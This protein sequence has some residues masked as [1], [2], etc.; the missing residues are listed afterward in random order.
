MLTDWMP[1]TE[2]GSA[3]GFIWMSS[4]LGGALAP[5]LIGLLI[6]SLGNW[7]SAL[8]VVSGLGVLWCVAFWPWFRNLPEEMPRVNVRERKLIASGRAPMPTAHHHAAPW[9]AMLRCGSGWALCLTYGCLGYSGNFFLTLLPVYLKT[10]R[11]LD[12]NT[13]YWLTS[14]PFA[15]GVVACIVGGSLSDVLL[16]RW[17][18]RRWGRPLVGSIGMT[19]AGVAILGTV[20]VRDVPLLGLLL[21][22]TFVGNDL[23]MGPAW[24]AAADI[25]ERHAGTLG[26]TMNMIAS[27]TAA[28]AALVTGHLLESGSIM[29]PFILFAG[30]YALGA[31]CWL[32]VDITRPLIVADD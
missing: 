1:T 5:L 14:L 19:I 3:Q 15:C 25:G 13:I 24:A 21:C 26:G 29:L 2:R 27:L 11:K 8:A 12:A 9:R 7:R 30:S 18:N 20:W 10:H 16:K 17:G 32:R 31:L 23:A 22:L 28:L 4:R 6:A